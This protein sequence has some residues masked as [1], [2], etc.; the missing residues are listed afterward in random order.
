MIQG[1]SGVKEVAKV[2]RSDVLFLQGPTAVFNYPGLRISN[3]GLLEVFYTKYWSIWPIYLILTI[4]RPGEQQPKNIQPGRSTL[5][6]HGPFFEESQQRCH[7]PF[8]SRRKEPQC[9]SGYLPS[10]PNWRHFGFKV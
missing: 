1:I 5:V 8:L 10:A 7:P 9:A 6:I 3:K 2:L 4:N